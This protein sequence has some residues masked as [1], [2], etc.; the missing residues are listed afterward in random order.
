M[1]VAFMGVNKMSICKLNLLNTPLFLQNT[2]EKI[3]LWLIMP[4]LHIDII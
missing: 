1:K 2:Q 3:T 4:A